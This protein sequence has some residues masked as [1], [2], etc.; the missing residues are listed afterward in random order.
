MPLHRV[1][2][3][4]HTACTPEQRSALLPSTFRLPAVPA[5]QRQLKLHPDLRWLPCIKL[6]GEDEVPGQP[7]TELELLCERLCLE[8]ASTIAATRL[9]EVDA[10]RIG[11]DGLRALFTVKS[12]EL[13]RWQRLVAEVYRQAP[14]HRPSLSIAPAHVQVEDRIVEAWHFRLDVDG[15]LPL[16]RAVRDVRIAFAAVTAPRPVGQAQPH[17]A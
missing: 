4:R 5:R 2:P 8:V 17:A 16:R 14:Q 13:E 1:L 12:G 3:A 9:C 10:V 11:P 6:G 7:L 15:I